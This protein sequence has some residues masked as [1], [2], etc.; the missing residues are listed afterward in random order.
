MESKQ[1]DKLHSNRSPGQSFWSEDVIDETSIETKDPVMAGV[2]KYNLAQRDLFINKDEIN[3]LVLYTG[4]TL[5]MSKVNGSYVPI[6]NWLL[7]KL[8][9]NNLFYDEQYS[10]LK[11]KEGTSC[12]PK[13]YRGNRLRYHINEF[14]P[15]IDSSELNSR[16]YAKIAEAIEKEYDNYDSFIVIYGTDTM[17]YMASQ[18]SFMFENLSKTI[19]FTGSQI[20]ISEW[21][22]DAISNLIGS[23]TVAEHRIPE[24]CVFFNGVLLRGNRTCKESSTMFKAFGSPNFPELATFDVFLNYRKDLI[25]KPPKDADKFMVFKDLERKIAV[26]YVHPMITSSIFLSAFKRAKAI[27]L[28]TYGM[29][30]FPL[31]RVDLVEII[32]D[33]IKK[34]RK[35][36]VIVSQCRKGFVRG[37]Y[38]SCVE[39]CKL[40]VILAEDMTLE[41]VIAKLAYILGKGY[42]GSDVEKMMLTNL[43]GEISIDTEVTGTERNDEKLSKFM[44]DFEDKLDTQNIKDL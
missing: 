28:Q 31:S 40:G 26:V 43:R 39:L 29:G 33:A 24:V 30:N 42:R 10:K 13:T 44:E 27:I 35:T 9:S 23:F 8:H 4:G 6:K 1:D 3:I 25:L 36:V 22:N 37:N 18:L 11:H 32:E 21:R 12:T 7:Q 20:P 41:S 34:Y 38:A 15:L 5:G 16:Y 2:R 17:A 14:D 19:W